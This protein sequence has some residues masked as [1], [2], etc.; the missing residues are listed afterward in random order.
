M[1][2]KSIPPSTE[3]GKL[4]ESKIVPE[5][6]KFDGSA[7]SRQVAGPST[8]V[9]AESRQLSGPSTGGIGGMSYQ[10]IYLAIG[11]LLK[12]SPLFFSYIFAFPLTLFD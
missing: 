11:K 2:Y 7:E 1:S 8:A 5:Y 6:G 3:F 9:P 12:S 4:S 10:N